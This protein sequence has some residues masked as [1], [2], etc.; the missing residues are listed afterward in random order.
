MISV[1]VSLLIAVLVLGIIYWIVTLFPLAE[2]FRRIALAI[3]ALIFLI[4]LVYLLLPVA[5]RS[6]I[7]Y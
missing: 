1:L 4:W 3:L 7:F 2:P 5:G 6:H